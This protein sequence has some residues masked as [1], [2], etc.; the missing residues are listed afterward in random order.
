MCACVHVIGLQSALLG[1]VA[2]Q[3]K[4]EPG[5]ALAPLLRWWTRAICCVFFMQDSSRSKPRNTPLCVGLQRLLHLSL[6]K[7]NSSF[8]VEEEEEEADCK[9]TV[10]C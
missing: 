7:H 1:D 10:C 3:Q 5:S 2:L 6:Q 8:S 4:V 9:V